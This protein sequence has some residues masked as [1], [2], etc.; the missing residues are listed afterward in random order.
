MINE[1]SEAKVIT[2][3]KTPDKRKQMKIG[4]DRYKAILNAIFDNPNSVPFQAVDHILYPTYRK[5]I[6]N[7]DVSLSS[8]REDIVCEDRYS[9]ARFCKDMNLVFEN[10]KEFFEE[11]DPKIYA[12]ALEL[13]KFYDKEMDTVF[14][15]MWRQTHKKSLAKVSKESDDRVSGDLD[16][17]QA[18]TSKLVDQFTPD[19]SGSDSKTVT[20]KPNLKINKS[21]QTQKRSL[22]TVR[23]SNDSKSLAKS[24]LNLKKT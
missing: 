20:K 1:N 23:N 17:N 8:I 22:Q 13:E 5:E 21:K 16:F 19:E 4:K 11:E 15:D 3:N 10:A 2:G 7:A 9:F 12:M 6:S 24:P 14:G 18:S